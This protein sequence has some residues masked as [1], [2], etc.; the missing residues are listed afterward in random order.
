MQEETTE[1]IQQGDVLQ[2][3]QRVSFIAGA[4]GRVDG[5]GYSG[6]SQA[7]SGVIEPP[8]QGSA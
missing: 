4:I 1:G 5:A 3:I 7:H 8:R 6:V 2:R